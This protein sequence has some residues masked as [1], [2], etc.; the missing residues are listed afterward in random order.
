MIFLSAWGS[1]AAALNSLAASSVVD[2]HQRVLPASRQGNPYNVSRWYTLGWGLFSILI[3]QFST[4]LGQSLIEAVNVLG[5][6]FYGDILGIFLVAFY[7]KKVGGKATFAAALTI[8]IFIVLLFFNNN[9]SF[10]SWLPDV[11]FLWLN[12]LG[13]A[14]VVLLAA[15][16]QRLQKKPG[17]VVLP[18]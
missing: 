18:G 13:A 16:L 1:I 9:I 15:A 5:S 17:S 4:R 12:V 3:A 14:G 8:E 10:L 11:S 6:L 7:L 2:I